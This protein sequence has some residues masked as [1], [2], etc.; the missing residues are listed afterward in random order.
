[1]VGCLCKAADGGGLNDSLTNLD[2]GLA[3]LDLDLGV[4][5]PQVVE[6]LIEIELTCTDH[7]MFT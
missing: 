6:D 7:N 3:D 5:G 4:E 1:M 2:E